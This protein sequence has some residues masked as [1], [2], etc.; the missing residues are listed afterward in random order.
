M[1]N[2][3]QVNE[4]IDAMDVEGTTDVADPL[5]I[6]Q[7]VFDSLRPSWYLFYALV[8]ERQAC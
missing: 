3:D 5:A 1:E 8:E 6:K 4:F 7:T 2:V